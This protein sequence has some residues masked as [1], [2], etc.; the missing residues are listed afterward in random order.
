MVDH[1]VFKHVGYDTDSQG[2]AFGVG[3]ERL[4][5][6]RYGIDHIKTFMKMTKVFKAVLMKI[7]K[8]WL[9][10]WIDIEN[11]SNSDISEALESLGFEIEN[12]K[13]LNL[14]MKTSL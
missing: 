2:F 9:N 7:L 11:I 6:I 10:D 4:A 3:V 8:S 12:K 14:I 13:E 1:N 5:M